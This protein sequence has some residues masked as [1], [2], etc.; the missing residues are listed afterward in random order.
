M[1]LLVFIM[2]WEQGWEFIKWLDTLCPAPGWMLAQGLSFHLLLTVSL[3]TQITRH[4]RRAT[5]S[6]PG[7]PGPSSW[8]MMWGFFFFLVLDRKEWDSLVAQTVDTCSAGDLS[9]IPGSGR[10]PGEGNY[11]PLQYSFL[12]N[13]VERGTWW[14]TA[15]RV[16]K[17]Q[18]TTERLH[19]HFHF[20]IDKRTIKREDIKR[21][22]L[23]VKHIH[24]KPLEKREGSSFPIHGM[25][26]SP[27]KAKNVCDWV[28]RCGLQDPPVSRREARPRR[29]QSTLPVLNSLDTSKTVFRKLCCFGKCTIWG[30]AFL[31]A[32]TA[33]NLPPTRET[34][35]W[36]LGQE[37]PL[38][39]MEWQPTPVF[40]PAEFQGQRSLV[41]YSPW[42]C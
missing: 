17:S 38:E 33:K 5:I 9:L 18:D 25:R 13:P 10:S 28:L 35:V 16:T 8:L 21:R 41:G 29:D 7:K 11:N 30:R 6:S 42:C 22:S 40:L 37:G 19:F 14:A 31:V 2:S 27:K 36:S 4:V 26:K 23:T 1:P 39:K 12:E 24:H 34:Q 3:N 32:P 15:Q 20:Q